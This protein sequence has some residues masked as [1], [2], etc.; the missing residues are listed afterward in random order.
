MRLL[1]RALVAVAFAASTLGASTFTASA[2]P[3]AARPV[4]DIQLTLTS[5]SEP[6]SGEMATF[7][8]A[9]STSLSG[10]KIKLLRRVGKDGDW[11]KVAQTRIGSDGTFAISGVATGVGANNWRASTKRDGRKHLSNVATTTVFGWY[12][13]SELERVD[14]DGLY[15]DGATVGGQNYGKS[16][17]SDYYVADDGYDAWAEWNLSYRCKQLEAFIGIDDDAETGF[18]ADFGAYLDGAETSWGEMGLGPATQVTLDTSSRLRLK[19]EVRP[20]TGIE[21]SGID[22]SGVFGGARV[23]CSGKP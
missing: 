12:Y 10:A 1:I 17:V 4:K 2:G 20:G 16:V 3:I 6:V 18:K 22:G 8:G 14:Y 21:G 5:T 23:L 11:V 7:T 13:L 19:L 15:P 9:A